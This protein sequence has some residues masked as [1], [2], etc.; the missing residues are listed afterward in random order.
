MLAGK[1]ARIIFKCKINFKTRKFR[2]PEKIKYV[3]ENKYKILII[4]KVLIKPYR[5]LS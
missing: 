2:E 5:K 4:L 1:D 3:V